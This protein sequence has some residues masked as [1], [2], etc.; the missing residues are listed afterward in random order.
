MP[1]DT[2]A[3]DPVEALLAHA[4]FYEPHAPYSRLAR[5][6]RVLMG[7]VEAGMLVASEQEAARAALSRAR[8]IAEGGTINEAS[9]R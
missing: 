7:Y 9:G 2:P 1:A 3:T 8:E 5:I 4:E 6:V